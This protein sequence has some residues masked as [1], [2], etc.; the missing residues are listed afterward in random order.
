M[1]SHPAIV[2]ASGELAAVRQ[3]TIADYLAE[4]LHFY[5]ARHLFG[6]PGDYVI[7][8]WDRIQ[9]GGL[10]QTV[11]TCDEQGAGFA[12]DAYARLRGIGALAHT[13]GV[14]GIKALHT[15]AESYTERAPVVV[16]SGA[17]GLR[18][19]S[20]GPL[21]HHL[22]EGFYTQLKMFEQVTV[23]STVL[24]DPMQAFR[25][26]DRVLSAA[27]LHQRPVYIEIPRDQFLV[28]GDP[29]HAPAEFRR[30]GSNPEALQSAVREAVERINHSEMPV[31][32][33]GV[34]LQRY[35]LQDA[36]QRLLDASNIPYATTILGKAVLSETNPLCMGVY[37]GGLTPEAVRNYVE[38]SDCI[39]MLGTIWTDVNLGLFSARIDTHGTVLATS[40]NVSVG[41]T[42]YEQVTLHDFVEALAD[43]G[44]DHR[45]GL[46]GV[47]VPRLSGSPSNGM[48]AGFHS[49][50]GQKITTARLFAA[51]DAFLDD[52][53]VITAD[54]GE[55]LIAGV[56]LFIPRKNG[57]FAPGYYT[58]VGYAVPT[59]LG[60]QLA[61]PQC[62]PVVLVGDAAFQMTGVEISTMI[63]CGLNPI[64]IVLNN[65][66]YGS[67]RPIADAD[68]V[69]V[70]RWDYTRFVEVF[71]AGRSFKVLTEEELKI[72]LDEARAYT[73]SFVLIDVHLEKFDYSP[74]FERFL[75]L[76][77]EG[78]R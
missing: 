1:L 30:P 72:A 58:S 36:L 45:E 61:V 38:G 48:P 8:L 46:P 71:Q 47:K 28:E 56:D 9:R 27:I 14:G 70:R 32:L 51:V 2:P 66:G 31:I 57:F 63:R 21:L 34:E 37:Q 7:T 16:I 73:D 6:I 54:N 59:A 43:S 17:P 3:Q 22:V 12:A 65:G 69:D 50:P 55:T 19:R 42:N 25:E 13:Y 74:S 77:A 49:V 4:R 15:T 76:F 75:G 5:G 18:E 23:A 60:V 26:I 64:V 53:N 78:A 62:R 40:E 68:F 67:E 39:I 44:L 52:Q 35:R 11:N 29:D 10:L 41:R 20:H 33:A 24:E